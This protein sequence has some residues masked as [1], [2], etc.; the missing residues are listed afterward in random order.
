MMGKKKLLCFEI[1]DIISYLG[2]SF[3]S[4]GMSFRFFTKD[5]ME[6]LS[7]SSEICL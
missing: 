3:L 6:S 4:G 1:T 7:S 5:S 2:C